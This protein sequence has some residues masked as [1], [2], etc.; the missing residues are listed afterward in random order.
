MCHSKLLQAETF[1][2]LMI[3]GGRK[4][5]SSLTKKSK[6]INV[7]IKYYFY[8][9]KTF[10]EVGVSIINEDLF[11]LANYKIVIVLN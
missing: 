8:K 7:T 4:L 11:C 10:H 9:I 1:F 3:Q 5:V 2:L 6:K